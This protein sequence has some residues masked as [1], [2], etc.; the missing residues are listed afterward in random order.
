MNWSRSSIWKIFTI[1]MSKNLIANVD[2]YTFIPNIYLFYQAF[3]YCIRYT[4]GYRE[5][6][7]KAKIFVCA[8]GSC[9][10]FQYSWNNWDR[11]IIEINFNFNRLIQINTFRPI[12]QETL[13]RS[14]LLAMVRHRLPYYLTLSGRKNTWTPIKIPMSG[15]LLKYGK[16]SMLILENYSIVLCCH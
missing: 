8:V 4:V 10:Y 12:T 15:N 2:K 16:V 6:I 7:V 11:E 1:N 5:P 13:M 9:E 3:Q 14:N